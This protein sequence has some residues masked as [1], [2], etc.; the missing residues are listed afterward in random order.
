M[1]KKIKKYYVNPDDSAVLAMSV[2]DE[3]A[4]ESNFVYLSKQQKIDK[5]VAL[6]T[7]EKHMIYGAAL[8]PDFPIYRKDE[9]E[10]YYLEFSR[11]AVERLARDFMINGLQSNFTAGHKR[12]VDGITITESWIKVDMEKDKSLALGIDAEL[13]VGS[14]IIGGYV[15]NNDIWEKVKAGEYHGFSVEAVVNLN[16]LAFEEQT[17]TPES[18]PTVEPVQEPVV[19][20]TPVQEPVVEAPKEKGIINKILELINGG[21]IE[22]VTEKPVEEPKPEE[23][24]PVQE[25]VVE[26]ATEPETKPE[27]QPN[28]LEEV[29]KNLQDEIKAL[30]EKN[31]LLEGERD[32]LSKKVDDMAGQP[33]VKP[34]NVNGGEAGNDSFHNWRNQ[35]KNMLR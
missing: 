11:E 3:P 12:S 10:E 32:A 22:T 35:M 27:P 28:P 30:K 31:E 34:T 23:P 29:V 19:E 4:V 6:E 33:S 24:A 21:D 8:R 14:W 7:N 25:P 13:P 5:F 9:D 1:K 2:V 17:P 15:D 16:E 20:S 18:A 26:P